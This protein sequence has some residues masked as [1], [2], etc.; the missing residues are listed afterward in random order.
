L[1]DRARFSKLFTVRSLVLYVV[2]FLV[3]VIATGCG[4]KH[5]VRHTTSTIKGTAKNVHLEK[6]AGALYDDDGDDDDDEIGLACPSP[7]DDDDAQPQPP[8]VLTDAI[9][10]A[11]LTPPPFRPSPATLGPARGHPPASERPPRA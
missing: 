7:D 2:V 6:R 5:E 1:T 3:A 10:I 4:T 9:A 8:G 11:I